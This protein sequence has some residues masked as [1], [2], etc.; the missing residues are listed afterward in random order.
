VAADSASDVQLQE[1]GGVSDALARL[2]DEK[3][4]AVM[5]ANE[6]GELDGLR[7]AEGVRAANPELPIVVLG[8]E[9][10]QELAA[11]CY[12]VGADAYVC[13]NTATTRALLW[14]VGR[15]IHFHRLNAENRRLAQIQRQRLTQEHDE[16]HR[17][18]DQQRALI[19]GLE[20]MDTEGPIAVELA[21]ADDRRHESPA[22]LLQLP[23]R[24]VEHYRDLL[25]AYVVMGSGNISGEMKT[26]AGLLASAGV[27]AEQTMLLH[28]EVL[29][30]LVQG[31]GSRSAR[32]VLNRADLLVLDV[33]IHLAQEYRR[34]LFERQRPAR[35]RLL[36]GF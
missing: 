26:L 32:H 21:D 18:L 19:R 11:L 24:L 7:F 35:Q 8:A 34:R 23:A 17:L 25:R 9:S 28:L 36:P 10:E 33:M 15:A 4:D 3:F 29:S 2:R 14:T 20:A 13:V 1:A 30:E 6:P 12:E 5:L 27:C 22:T 16:V 31:L